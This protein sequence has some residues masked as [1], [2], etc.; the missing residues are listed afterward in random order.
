MRGL[1]E[2]F[3]FDLKE[4]KLVGLLEAVKQDDT[5]CLKIRKNYINIYY[6][7]GSILKITSSGQDYKLFFDEKYL[8]NE[9]SNW[10]K[11]NLIN[12]TSITDYVDAIPFLKREMDYWLYKHPKLERE[13]QQIILRDNNFSS[14]ANDTDYYITDIEYANSTNGS[15]FDLLGVKWLSTGPSRKKATETSLALMEF[16]YGDNALT[17]SSGI[18]KHFADMGKFAKNGGIS[19]LILET[20]TQFNQKIDLGLIKGIKKHIEINTQIKPEFI[21]ICANHKPA[22]TILIRELKNAHDSYPDLP[23]HFDIKIAT[24]SYVGYGLYADCMIDIDKF[25]GE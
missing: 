21:I 25:I 13:Y 16:K 9:N 15:R 2:R 3:M 7:G 4:G 19:S 6:R 14:I 8:I 17:G 1:S 23:N 10:L 20:Q 12:L 5:L 24:A 22:S 11:E 18:L